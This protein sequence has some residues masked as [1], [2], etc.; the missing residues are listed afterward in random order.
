MR[1]A[2]AGKVGRVV[3]GHCQ[4]SLPLAMKAPTRTGGWRGGLGCLLLHA[5][6]LSLE[7]PLPPAWKC[8][9]ESVRRKNSPG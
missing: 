9:Q 1:G 7:L 4:S 5:P 6:A 2:C 3:E 8:P